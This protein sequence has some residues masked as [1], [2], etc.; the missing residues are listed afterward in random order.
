MQVGY[1]PAAPV[2][3]YCADGYKMLLGECNP[4]IG[5]DVSDAAVTRVVT[6]S[7]L[8]RRFPPSPPLHKMLLLIIW[9]CL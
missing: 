5:V 1:D 4:C 2:C 7:M 6:L 3:G 9:Q 8:V